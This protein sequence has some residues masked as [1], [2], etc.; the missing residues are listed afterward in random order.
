METIRMADKKAKLIIELLSSNFS[1]GE[2]KYIMEVLS[3]ELSNTNSMVLKKPLLLA[4]K[5][6][7]S[8]DMVALAMKYKQPLNTNAANTL[9]DVVFDVWSPAMAEEMMSSFDCHLV[10]NEQ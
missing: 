2:L 7:S 4:T 5:S 3:S 1:D 10:F 8:R 6:L 9:D